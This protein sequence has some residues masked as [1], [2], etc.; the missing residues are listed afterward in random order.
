MDSAKNKTSN[1]YVQPSYGGANHF[2][3]LQD[4]VV[5][6]EGV[7][8]SENGDQVSHLC[9]NPS[10]T[11]FEHMCIESAQKNN[12]RKGCVGLVGVPPLPQKI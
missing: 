3:V 11:L 1:G 8:L 12:G 5:W 6:S 9:G 7:T 2:A 4:I 10:C